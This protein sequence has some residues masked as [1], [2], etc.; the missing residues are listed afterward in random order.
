MAADLAKGSHLVHR[1]GVL[2]STPYAHGARFSPRARAP[3][4]A[5]V[6]SNPVD[7]PPVPLG[8]DP[9][10]NGFQARI[11]HGNVGSHLTVMGRG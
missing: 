8:L 7:S 1:G 6:Q 10:R 3:R 2:G 11:R 4:H 9:V 5:L